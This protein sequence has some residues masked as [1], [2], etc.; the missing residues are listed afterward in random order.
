MG[1]RRAGTRARFTVDGVSIAS[2]ARVG[3]HGPRLI[4]L[5][6]ASASLTNETWFLTGSCE[7]I[8]GSDASPLRPVGR[9]ARLQGM[10]RACSGRGCC[11]PA[12]R[13]QCA[14]AKEWEGARARYY[15]PP[16]WPRRWTEHAHPLQPYGDIFPCNRYTMPR[17]VAVTDLTTTTPSLIVTVMSLWQLFYFSIDYENSTKRSRLEYV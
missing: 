8:R 7:R 6:S 4:A 15:R 1:T 13:T 9:R 12:G 11:L 3:S 16:D 10:Q 2:M 17:S 14:A 5:A